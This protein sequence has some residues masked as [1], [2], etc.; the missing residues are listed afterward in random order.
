VDS[1]LPSA[2]VV[3]LDEI[4]KAGPSIQNTLL[5]VL[6][7][8]IFR[9]G[10]KEISVPIKA[11]IS[12]SNELPAKD[13]GLEA[14]WDRFLVR[15][16]VEGIE[17]EQ[18][19]YEM[20]EMS[21][22]GEPEIT[23]SISDDDYKKWSKD[24]DNIKIPDNVRQVIDVIREYIAQYNQQEGN[25]ENRIHI[26]DRRWR[27]IVRLLRTST[28]LNDRAEVDLMDCFLIRHC[29]WNEQE[30]TEAAF[31]FVVDAIEKY[32]P[33]FNTSLSD[34]FTE[35]NRLT[36]EIEKNTEKKV[37]DIPKPRLD[38][39][40]VEYY[41]IKEPIETYAFIKSEDVLKATDDESDVE[42][43]LEDFATP[44]TFE[45]KKSEDE[46]TISIFSRSEYSWKNYALETV[47]EFKPYKKSPTRGDYTLWDNET[48]KLSK[49]LVD[50]KGEA[51]KY[52]DTFSQSF[53]S[54][55]F[56]DKDYADKYVHNNIQN[57]IG[58]IEKLELSVRE[59]R[60][61][62]QSIYKDNGK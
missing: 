40:G 2:D 54:N 8:K 20:T 3:F 58:Q 16:I 44:K 38:T 53:Y 5:T 36:G 28:F 17:D 43:Y 4:W 41:Q 22:S 1:Y 49:C 50:K 18:K 15:L 6:N 46:N 10:E 25:A 21:Q 57:I 23:N 9:N 39:K 34:E 35:F 11:L 32:G 29:I 12:A 26:S 61:K 56:V 33:A 27:K 51:K 47:P 62:Y 24:I 55:L 30:Q 14:L 60:D 13:Q 52:W 19:F 59:L 7:E 45:I 48:E 31:Q 37:G 42:I